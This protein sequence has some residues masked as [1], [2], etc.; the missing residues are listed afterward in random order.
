MS[1]A[2]VG[3]AQGND[4][5]DHLGAVKTS[6]TYTSV[7]QPVEVT[8]QYMVQRASRHNVFEGGAGYRSWWLEFATVDQRLFDG[9]GGRSGT[10]LNV[11]CYDAADDFMFEFTFDGTSYTYHESE[12]RRRYIHAFEIERIPLLV[13]QKTVRFEVVAY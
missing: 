10:R 9:N 12:T 3:L 5:L 2:L 8:D 13:L 11:K 1:L 6:F 4:L 7:N